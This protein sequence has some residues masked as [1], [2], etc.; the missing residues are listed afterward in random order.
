M[1]PT[2][3]CLNP[4]VKRKQLERPRYSLII[5]P[6]RGYLHK[7]FLWL[8]FVNAQ[9][10]S[11]SR[12][13]SVLCFCNRFPGEHVSPQ[14]CPRSVWEPLGTMPDL[15]GP[16]SDP[17][18]YIS[19]SVCRSSSTHLGTMCDQFPT[20]PDASWLLPPFG[21]HS[22]SP[23]PATGV[24]RQVFEIHTCI[25]SPFRCTFFP[26]CPVPEHISPSLR[27]SVKSHLQ[28]TQG[29]KAL[30]NAMD[31]DRL[32]E[33]HC[34]TNTFR[35]SRSMGET[36]VKQTVPACPAGTLPETLGNKA[37]SS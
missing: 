30:V 25:S 16:I 12:D 21:C 28:L 17:F 32:A 10:T 1:L 19:L 8:Q 15:L 3:T 4:K 26:F 9:R 5:P 6:T 33:Y 24:I 27:Y 18:R 34:K 36:I 11:Q 13:F 31:H 23:I 7:L 20:H 35:S 22:P 2:Q 29:R 37:F 14:R